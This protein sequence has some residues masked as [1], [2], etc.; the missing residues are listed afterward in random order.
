MD[1]F[2][3]DT[4]SLVSALP[5]AIYRSTPDGRFAAGNE[6]LARLLGADSTDD[7][8]DVPIRSLY[9]DP[10]DRDSMVERAAAGEAIPA[11]EIELRRLDGRPIWVRVNS[12]TV[13]GDDGEV[14]FYEG[15]LED[16][17]E[18]RRAR[19]ELVRNHE[20]LDM[21][22]E[23]QNG[24]IAGADPGPL[25]DRML[26][27]LL[28]MSASEYGFIAQIRHDE[29]GSPFLRT[30]AMSNI[31]WNEETRRLF[32]ERGPRR[33]EFHNFANLFGHAVTEATPVISNDPQSDPRR[34]GHPDGHP[35]LE[36]FLGIPIVRG[37]DVLGMVAVANRPDGYDEGVAEELQ[38]LVATVGSM[39]EALRA[40]EARSAA[41]AGIRARDE[42]YR[43]LVVHAAEGVVAFDDEGTIRA[44]NPAAEEIT[45][46]RS[47]DVID[48]SIFELLPAEVVPPLEGGPLPGPA[49][50]EAEVVTRTGERV[51]VEVAF[52]RTMLDG[53]SITTAIMH[54]VAERRAM[55]AATLQA[56]D[57][58][59]RASRAKDEFLAG[60]SHELRTPLNGVIGLSSILDRGVH[61]P[62]NDK[63]LEYVRQITTSGRHLLELINDILDLAKIEADKLEPDLADHELASI[64][65]SAVSLVRETAVQKGLQISVALDDALPPVTVDARY[66]KQILINLLSNAIKFTEPGGAVKVVG[67][68]RGEP[69]EISVEDDGIGIPAAELDA[70]FEPFRQVGPSSGGVHQGTGLGLTLSRR[71]AEL[72]GGTLTVVSE[73]GRGSRFTLT[74]QPT[75]EPE[76]P[77]ATAHHDVGRGNEDGTA[78]PTRILLVED[79]P[80]NAMMVGD[81]L[82]AN[83]F[84]VINADDGEEA[85]AT[86][87][88]S[89]PDAILMDI[90]IPKKDGLTATRELK[91]DAAT[92]RIPIIALTALAMKGDAERCLDAGC[93]DYLSKPCD[94]DDIV[95]ALNRVLGTI[96]AT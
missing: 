36:A 88:A 72:Q 11:E 39:I 93:D 71:F 12:R 65:E 49:R 77:E 15:V 26:D 35:P 50:R 70:I 59:E 47:A 63:Q 19:D 86:A 17:T 46:F 29:N 32:E 16:V 83:G 51:P 64:V 68:N 54:N 21:L 56:K 53:R 13:R 80:V 22:T 5:V 43:A 20:L 94:P 23:I 28:R 74:L 69:V 85:V 79:N 76:Q 27:D 34:G 52:G 60:M 41:E 87:R 24:F 40:E 84:E 42:L 96:P 31:A 33:M 48:G 9:A 82:R 95:A 4:D 1:P 38:P 81:Y 3:S 30:H 37:S 6:A 45:G 18:I 61:G 2:L 58:A 91:A 73:V 92:R 89:T 62:L 67:T 57:A 7:L 14:V 8:V 78:G 75:I 25:F 90:Q 55:E 44:F 10:A 66:T